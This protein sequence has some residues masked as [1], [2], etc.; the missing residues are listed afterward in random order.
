VP[1]GGDEFS[2]ASWAGYSAAVEPLEIRRRVAENRITKVPL[3]E[4]LH[5]PTVDQRTRHRF[6]DR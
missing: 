1:N 6:S 4:M 2:S 5:Y 3:P